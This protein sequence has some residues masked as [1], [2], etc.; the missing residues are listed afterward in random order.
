MFAQGKAD[1]PLFV[2]SNRCTPAKHTLGSSLVAFCASEITQLFSVIFYVVRAV[3]KF[4]FRFVTNRIPNK[5]RRV[6]RR[7]CRDRDA[8]FNMIYVYIFSPNRHRKC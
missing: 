5:W 2:T 4:E 7:L 6:E 1:S 3:H 8:R